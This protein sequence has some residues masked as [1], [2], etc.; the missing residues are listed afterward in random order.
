MKIYAYICN[1]FEYLLKVKSKPERH[2]IIREVVSNGKVGSQEELAAILEKR[3]IQV[4]QATLSRDIRD[5]GITKLHDGG[6]YYYSL[7]KGAVHVL[8]KTAV[9]DMSGIVSSVEY[10]GQIAVLKTR[11][12]HANMVASFIDSAESPE[13]V[14]T[15]AGDDTIFLAIREGVTRGALSSTLEKVLVGLD[16]S[17]FN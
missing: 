11:P 4:A 10:T 12:G 8:P 2:K 3:G 16:L 9:P 14:G 5:L 17:L 15:I 1:E 7:P 13:I 6:G